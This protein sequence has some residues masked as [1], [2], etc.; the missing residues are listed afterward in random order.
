VFFGLFAAVSLTRYTLKQADAFDLGIYDQALW[1]YSVFHG[2]ENTVLRVKNILTDHF[3]PILMLLSPLYWIWSDVRMLLLFQSFIAALGC[4]PIYLIAKE[5]INN[6]VV[7]NILAFAYL[8][9]V[10]LQK[11]VEFDFHA[12]TLAA[13]FLAFAFYFALKEKVV[14]YFFCALLALACKENVAITSF[15]LGVYLTCFSHKRWVG[16][17]TMALSA[18]WLLAFFRI[19]VP[20]GGGQYVYFTYSKFGHNG[21]EAVGTILRRPQ[22]VLQTFFD[23]GVKVSV[24]ISFLSSYAFLPIISLQFWVILLPLFCEKFLSDRPVVW[25]VSFQYNTILGVFLAIATIF[26]LAKIKKI[27]GKKLMKWATILILVANMVLAY[28]YTRNGDF[29]LARLFSSGRFQNLAA[30]V[31]RLGSQIP[32]TASVWAQ[33]NILPHFSHR[34]HIFMIFSIFPGPNP[35]PLPEYLIVDYSTPS[36]YIKFEELRQK[37]D[38]LVK[39][40]NY[41]LIGQDNEARLYKKR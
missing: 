2:F 29:P 15:F 18:T 7:A 14:W 11:A 4:I 32:A 28:K 10:G 31:E 37:I 35:N 22:L 27:Y 38:Q 13:T 8:M 9:F 1:K 25:S 6:K 40:G 36:L 34:D 26:A 41:I 3:D 5:K 16:L 21:I 33:S 24:F 20:A 12:L 19:F 39:D 23:Q 17:I 30:D